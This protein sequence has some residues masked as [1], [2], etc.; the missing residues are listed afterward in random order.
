M[1]NPPILKDKILMAGAPGTGKSTYLAAFWDRIEK[2]AEDSSIKLNGI[3]PE[4]RTYLNS[5]RDSWLE[6]HSLERTKGFANQHSPL[7]ISIGD[8]L[9][10]SLYFPDISGETYRDIVEKRNWPEAFSSQIESLSKLMIFVNPQKL[11]DGASHLEL[12]RITNSI[13][14]DEPDDEESITE[15]EMPWSPELIPDQVKIIDLIQLLSCR[16]SNSNINKI[17]IIISAWDTVMGLNMTP[18]QYLKSGLPFL[19]QFLESNRSSREYAAFGVSAQGGDYLLESDM[20]RITSAFNST[21]IPF[22]CS[23]NIDGERSSDITYPVR[24]LFE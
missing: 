24:W 12:A 3:L 4:E 6:H 8:N 21:H 16:E 2:N 14:D 5:L 20:E 23:S 10:F 7:N 17:C 1:S 15:S 9:K 13:D 11:N 22:I 19:Y 18:N